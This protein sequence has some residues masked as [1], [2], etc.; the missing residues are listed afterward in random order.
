MQPYP[1]CTE[2]VSMLQIYNIQVIVEQLYC[3]AKAHLPSYHL[4]SIENIE[5]RNTDIISQ[6]KDKGNTN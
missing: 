3:C 1:T 5:E 6:Q 4:N 2:A